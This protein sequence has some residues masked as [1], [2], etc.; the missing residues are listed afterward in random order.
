MSE[1]AYDKSIMAL[2][3][4]VQAFGSVLCMLVNS[5]GCLHV[6]PLSGLL[7]TGRTYS[8]SYHPGCCGGASQSCRTIHAHVMSSSSGVREDVVLHLPYGARR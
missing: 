2:V 7:F 5:P 3:A 6:P 4:V 8:M 1:V